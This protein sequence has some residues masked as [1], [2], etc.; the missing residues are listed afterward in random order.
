MGLGAL[1]KYNNNNPDP[2]SSPRV[3]FR[4]RAAVNQPV[5]A[6]SAIPGPPAAHLHVHNT[7]YTIYTYVHIHKYEKNDRITA[8][9]QISND[10][11]FFFFFSVFYHYIF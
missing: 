1:Q 2:L 4:P 11:R 6:T 9:R 5:A 10:F 7:L 3:Y 8:A